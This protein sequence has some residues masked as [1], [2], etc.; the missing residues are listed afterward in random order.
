MLFS[1]FLCKSVGTGAKKKGLSYTALLRPPWG[2]DRPGVHIISLGPS[3]RAMARV[4][5]EAILISL[6]G[7][8]I[9]SGLNGVES[10]WLT[11]TPVLRSHTLPPFVAGFRQNYSATVS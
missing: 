6:T 4:F 8:V 1:A 3:L 7:S 11:S 5:P 10:H 9:S 2:H